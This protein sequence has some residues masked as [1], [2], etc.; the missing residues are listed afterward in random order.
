MRFRL[1]PGA[2][3]A[4]ALF[5]AALWAGSFS[6]STLPPGESSDKGTLINTQTTITQSASMAVVSGTSIGCTDP[7]GISQVNKWLRRFDLNGVYGIVTPFA[8]SS[9]D[10]GVEEAATATGT[11][12]PLTIN[13]YTIPNAAPML[14]ANMTLVGTTT[15]TLPDQS[16]TN[17]NK[18]VLGMVSNPNA[19]D[20][21]VEISCPSTGSIFFVGA[22]SAGQT[23]P[24]YI[25]TADCGVTDPL[26]LAAIGFPNMHMVLAVH[27]DQAV[28]TDAGSWGRLKATYR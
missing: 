9:V 11:G 17:L 18:A 19:N 3:L 4:A 26:S 21:V 24:T 2:I 8:V 13:L 14:Y 25:A 16:L 22:N 10:F 12:Q 23:A 28:P 20:L 5:P 7:G 1:L 15:F 6:T 27:G